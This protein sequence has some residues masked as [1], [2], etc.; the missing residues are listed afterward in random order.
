MG[1]HSNRSPERVPKPPLVSTVAKARAFLAAFRRTCNVTKSAKAAGIDPRC[2]YRWLKKY[3]KYQ[4]AFER[5]IP[6]ATQFLEDK[7]IEGCTEG[8]LEA[9]FYQ[10]QPCGAVRRFDLGNRATLL[11][12]WMPEKYGSK[13]ELTGKDGGPIDSKLEVVF[14]RP[15][16]AELAVMPKPA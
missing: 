8:W 3:P 15:K 10:G 6:I 11:R 13:V 7:T 5:A 4:A 16:P 1:E 2:H 9:V 14:V 12:A